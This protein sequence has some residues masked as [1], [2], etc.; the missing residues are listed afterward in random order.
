MKNVRIC[1]VIME[2]KEVNKR[3][4]IKDQIKNIASCLL[5][6]RRK[7]DNIKKEFLPKRGAR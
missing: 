1:K 7:I 4:N 3:N 6:K 5:R 2:V